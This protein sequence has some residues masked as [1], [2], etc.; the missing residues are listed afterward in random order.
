MELEDQ[1]VNSAINPSENPLFLASPLF[2]KEVLSLQKETI[3][4]F[5]NLSSQV[6]ICRDF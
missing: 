6:C 4:N 1:D 3:N 5:S 2:G